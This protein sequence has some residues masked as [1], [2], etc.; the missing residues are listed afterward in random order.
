MSESDYILSCEST[1]DLPPEKVHEFGLEY[2]CYHYSLGGTEYTDDLGQ[3]IS[4]KEFYDRM[5]AGEDT[6]TSALSVGEYSEYFEGLLKQGKDVLHATLSSGI[7]SSEQAAEDAAAGLREKYPDQ[8][9]YVVDS[10]CISSGYG[11]VMHELSKKRAA[12]VG[13]DEARTWLIENRLHMHHCFYSS[14]LTYYVRGGRVT[15]TTGFVGN[16]LG[17]CP[18]LEINSE[19]KLI[20]RERKRGKK[21]ATR[22]LVEK[23]EEYAYNGTDYDGEAWFCHSDCLA[24]VEELVAQVKERFPHLSGEQLIC[25]IGP[26]IGAHSGPGTVAVFFWGSERTE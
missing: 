16:L 23:M 6:K 1:I 2:I 24:D 13:I 4:L 25:N 26:T 7:T 3:S 12:G 10:L 18:V 8:K 20:P 19:G 15:P 22:R 14:D 17:I 5:V 11:M 21:K 9:L